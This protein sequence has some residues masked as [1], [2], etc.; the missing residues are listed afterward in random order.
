MNPERLKRTSMY[1]CFVVASELVVENVSG[2]V[3]LD[4]VVGVACEIVDHH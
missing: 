3:A 1:A 4:A 2:E